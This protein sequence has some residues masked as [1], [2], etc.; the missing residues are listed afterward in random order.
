MKRV[1]LVLAALALQPVA[2]GTAFAANLKAEFSKAWTGRQSEY[3]YQAKQALA[4][5][6]AAIAAFAAIKAPDDPN[7]SAKTNEMLDAASEYG[8]V[9]GRLAQLM[10]LQAFFATNPSRA[11]TEIWLQARVSELQTLERKA[12]A[13]WRAARM[14]ATLEAADEGKYIA[15]VLQAVVF[16]GFVRGA[17]EE[18][19]LID[20]N[21]GTYF[22]AK[23]EKDDARRRTRA[24]IFGAIGG[25]LRQ[26]A[27]QPLMRPPTTV[28]C[29]TYGATTTCRGQ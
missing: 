22:R 24:A 16:N 4:R 29:D 10:G 13:E 3:A 14:P 5:Q 15:K 20:G 2:S 7:A 19:Q 9:Q 21:L 8:I 18:T 17:V 25:A 23:G 11:A 6:N 1:L 26:T 27:Q 28:R 12:D